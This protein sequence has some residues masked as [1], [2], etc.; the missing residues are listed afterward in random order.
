MYTQLNSSKNM[1]DTSKGKHNY[2]ILH[3]DWLLNILGPEIWKPPLKK[4]K[5]Q[6]LPQFYWLLHIL[7]LPRSRSMEATLT[8]IVRL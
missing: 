2:I 6:S 3:L 5:N 1:E 4:I 8:E 7:K